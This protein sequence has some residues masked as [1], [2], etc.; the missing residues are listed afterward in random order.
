MTVD[1]IVAEGTVAAD[2]QAMHTAV[3][4]TAEAVGSIVVALA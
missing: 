2:A 3:V 1:N 4:D